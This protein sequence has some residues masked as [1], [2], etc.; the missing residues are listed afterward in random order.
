MANLNTLPDL[1]T[2]DI[3]AI[4]DS[5]LLLPR[6]LL[7]PLTTIAENWDSIEPTV[8]N[9]EE[10]ENSC[11]DGDEEDS[12]E[13]DQSHSSTPRKIR[14]QKPHVKS[15][16]RSSSSGPD[17]MSDYSDSDLSDATSDSGDSTSSSSDSDSDSQSSVSSTSSKN[18]VPIDE[19]KKDHA[20]FSVREAN[21]DKGRVTLRLS[22]LNLYLKPN[23]ETRKQE[24]SKQASEASLSYKT[25]S[26]GMKG[27]K[28]SPTK[29]NTDL[30][31][32]T[33]SNKY[34]DSILSNINDNK[35]CLIGFFY[36]LELV[37]FYNF[38]F[39]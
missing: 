38:S 27:C 16:S 30:I 3:Q 9:P 19:A 34:H 5:G 31:L 25:E 4:Q 17:S 37:I 35:V 7:P 6:P 29:Q 21:F 26:V 14:Q 2:V 23:N 15:Y 1:S 24:V 32:P 28:T 22:S 11:S 18:V 13:E 12:D 39:L 33:H 36:F 20:S 10:N 8:R